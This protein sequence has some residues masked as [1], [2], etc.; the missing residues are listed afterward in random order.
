MPRSALI[1]LADH[2]GG[3]DDALV[4]RLTPTGHRLVRSPRIG[5]TLRELAERPPDLVVLR[6]LTASGRSEVA[7]VDRARGEDPPVPIL[8]VGERARGGAVLGTCERL[9][10]EDASW[11]FLFEDASPAELR[12][13]IARLLRETVRAGEVRELRH[14]AFHDDRT[15]LL[16]ADA[17]EA[18]LSE[19]VSAAQRHG[20]DLALVLIDLDDFGSV[21]KRFD[22]T[23]GDELIAKVG[24]VVRRN[25]R[26]EDVAG[27]LGGD[28]FGVILPYT[29][30]L[31]AARV[32][33]RLCEEVRRLSGRPG[34]SREELRVS[35]SIGYETLGGG[36]PGDAGGEGVVSA[37]DLRSHAERA[38]R[39]A[40]R[41]GGDR[42]VQFSRTEIPSPGTRGYEIR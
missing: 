39:E 11:D 28:E 34:T 41:L 30:P 18:R 36:P 42:G 1:L 8:V 14:R 5:Q 21:N 29:R 31:D 3:P 16:R 19:H 17:F 9:L 13:R 40:K 15:D 22:H 27:R 35:A 6:T 32:V 10:E 23:V 26:A 12:I 25:L 33:E 20:L 7:A 37:T 2:R 38:L 24:E 4:E